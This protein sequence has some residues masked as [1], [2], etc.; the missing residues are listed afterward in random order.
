MYRFVFFFRQ[1][2][3][4]SPDRKSDTYIKT[5]SVLIPSFFQ[6]LRDVLLERNQFIIFELRSWKAEAYRPHS[7]L[8]IRIQG[9]V[10]STTDAF[11]KELPPKIV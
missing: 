11:G 9:C 8:A 5:F 6:T 4:K 10:H 1:T 7:K 3:T 2:Q